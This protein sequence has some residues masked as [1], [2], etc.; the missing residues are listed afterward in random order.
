M[1]FILDLSVQSDQVSR[2]SKV[3]FLHHSFPTFVYRPVK[4]S[5]RLFEKLESFG[6]ILETLLRFKA[7]TQHET[8]CDSRESEDR[9]YISVNQ[10]CARNRD[11]M[12]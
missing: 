3:P 10:D 7:R 1:N 8:Y 11:T 6:P 12:P 5:L 2:T 9:Y 4:L